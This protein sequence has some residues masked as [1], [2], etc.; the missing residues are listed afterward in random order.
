MASYGPLSLD[1]DDDGDHIELS[2]MGQRRSEPSI[3][4]TAMDDDFGD[5]HEGEDDDG[6]SG[7]QR[8]PPDEAL[9]ASLQGDDESITRWEDPWL[10][11]VGITVFLIL[12]TLVYVTWIVFSI[13]G[14]MWSCLLFA[15]HLWTSVATAQCLVPVD[16]EL[17]SLSSP[18]PSPSLDTK[19]KF[20]HRSNMTCF[21]IVTSPAFCM[22]VALFGVV[23]PIVTKLIGQ[24]LFTDVD[25]TVVVEWSG[26][27]RAFKII[28]VLGWVIV[29][30][31]CT[32][33]LIS[34]AIRCCKRLYPQRLAR[35]GPTFWSVTNIC[36]A[37]D[38]IEREKEEEQEEYSCD[39]FGAASFSKPIFCAR[40]ARVLNL[41]SRASALLFVWCTLAAVSHF[42]PWPIPSQEHADCDPLDPTECILPFPSFFHMKPDLRT[43]TG[44][45]VDLKRNVLPPLRGGFFWNP[46]F[47]ND[48]DGFST[49]APMLFY[50]KGMKEAHERGENI[51][52][53][54]GPERIQ[55][56][57]T[58]SSVTLLLDV[59]SQELVYHSAEIDY[60]DPDRPLVMVFPAQPLKHNTHYALAVVN[61]ADEHGHRLPQTDG[62]KAVLKETNSYRRK[63]FHDVVIPALETAAPWFSFHKDP[64]S[65][66]LLFDFQTISEESQL[67]KVRGVLDATMKHL[68]DRSLWNWKD[69][70][71]TIAVEEGNCDAA[72]GTTL[73]ARTI[74]AELDVPW[75]LNHF[76]PGGRSAVINDDAVVSRKPVTIGRAKFMVRIPCSLREEAMGGVGKKLRAVMEYGHG[77]FGSR[78]EVTDEYLGR[79]VLATTIK[80][81]ELW[82][83]V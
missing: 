31:R 55:Y 58:S 35:W 18:S 26:D 81:H 65:L 30:L 24:A 57:A 16:A 45:R 14:R 83:F 4:H 8:L 22:D 68:D 5:E 32:I 59:E 69:H 80:P 70:V 46:S 21:R 41:F 12:P 63:R 1:D 28:R 9:A 50:L 34:L 67:G 25:G 36:G 2:D 38:Y 13:T 47:L 71:H 72:D 61:A 23:Y 15:V 29:G 66:Q 3:V 73:I 17:F 10:L 53:L 27:V 49:M 7:Q 82:D 56:S 40:L 79:Y 77:L 39:D 6:A 19:R 64:D 20:C 37:D 11:S 62:M 52:E 48:L 54:Q 43:A 44:W 76:G 60:L 51:V 33:G 78:S 74:H 42:G 75:F